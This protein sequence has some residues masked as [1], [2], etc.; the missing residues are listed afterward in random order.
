MKSI[1]LTLAFSATAFA[2]DPT[3]I[4]FIFSDDHAQ[5]AISAYGSKVNTTPK[6]KAMPVAF[7]VQTASRAKTLKK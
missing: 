6:R 2:A 3:N 4:L 7:C 1:L 5:H